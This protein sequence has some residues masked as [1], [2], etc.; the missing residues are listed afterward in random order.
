MTEPTKTV[1]QPSR[2]EQIWDGPVLVRLRAYVFPSL[3]F[4]LPVYFAQKFLQHLGGGALW[5]PRDW[6]E[7][8][9][10]IGT[11]IGLA[12]FNWTR[13]RG[14]RKPAV[15]AVGVK[16]AKKGAQKTATGTPESGHEGARAAQVSSLVW[17]GAALL[18]IGLYTFVRHQCVHPWQ[19]R[20][21]WIACEEVAVGGA[22]GLPSFIEL[23]P[24]SISS[25]ADSNSQEVHASES[26]TTDQ[27]RATSPVVWRGT[28]LTP[29][30]FTAA[31]RAELD[32]REQKH[33]IDGLQYCL[34]QDE[35]WL[36]DT[37]TDREQNAMAWTTLA[38]L[39]VHIS[40]LGFTAAGFGSS[41]TLSEELATRLAESG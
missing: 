37:L 11:A 23:T 1:A 26:S 33:G 5:F 39:L 12:A 36:I 35:S 16:H 21:A 19:P 15:T 41:F 20:A 13:L 8:V 22:E 38:F 7:V 29:I 10:V 31:T 18:C 9:S 28:F 25:G 40:V 3:A 27:P 30:G 24:H 17:Y 34:Q 2:F 4:A 14:R 32:R 6:R